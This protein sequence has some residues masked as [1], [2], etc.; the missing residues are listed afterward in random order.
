MKLVNSIMLGSTAAFFAVSGTQ[1]A[2]LPGH[3]DSKIGGAVM[4]AFQIKNIPTGPGNDIKFDA[5][6]A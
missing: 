3:P 1:A 2:D 4:A 5:S 6:W